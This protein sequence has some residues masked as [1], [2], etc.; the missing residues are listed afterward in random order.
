[1]NATPRHFDDC[2]LCAA[3][4]ITIHYYAPPLPMSNDDTEV[5]IQHRKYDTVATY[6]DGHRI[7]SYDHA[8][9]RGTV[10]GRFYFVKYSEWEEMIERGD[11]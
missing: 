7:G 10:K 9:R 3:E 6:E 8:A 1:M 5:T 11:Y 2:V 4:G